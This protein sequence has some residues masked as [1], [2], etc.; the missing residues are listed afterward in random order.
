MR[1]SSLGCG[2]ERAVAGWLNERSERSYPIELTDAEWKSV[3]PL[4]PAPPKRGRRLTT[5]LR[6][7]LCQ[8]GRKKAKRGSD[9]DLMVM[10]GHDAP[11]GLA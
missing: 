8:S 5:D 3:L 10:V 7:V 1:D 11:T 9:A 4:L 6:E 2:P